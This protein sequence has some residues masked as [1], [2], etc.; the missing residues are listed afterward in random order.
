MHFCPK[1]RNNTF[2]KKK[3]IISRLNV[4]R[5]ALKKS[6]M[7]QK[8][9]EVTSIQRESENN[10]SCHYSSVLRHVTQDQFL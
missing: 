5:E 2:T 10:T 1:S 9:K 8:V 3:K 6:V 4:S 7:I